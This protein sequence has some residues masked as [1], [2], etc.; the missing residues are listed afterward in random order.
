MAC[1]TG[2]I[3]LKP[4]NV[5]DLSCRELTCLRDKL[6]SLVLFDITTF[7]VSNVLISSSVDKVLIFGTVDTYYAHINFK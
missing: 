6:H 3:W 1:T 7:K 5:A 4:L 2:G